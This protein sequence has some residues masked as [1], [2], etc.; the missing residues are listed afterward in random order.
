[1]SYNRI[2][3]SHRGS[4]KKIVSDYFNTLSS[5]GYRPWMD[6]SDLTT[7]TALVKSLQEGM[8][9]SCAAV[10][11]V[12][13]AFKDEGYLR[14]EI[15]Y[16]LNQNE[17]W[18]N[19][20]TIITLIFDKNVKIPDPLKAY[21]YKYPTTHLEGLRIIINAIPKLKRI[22][23]YLPLPDLVPL[24]ANEVA[25]VGQNLAGRLGLG[26]EQ[27][28]LKFKEELESLLTRDSL[29]SLVL[30]MMTPKVL[31]SIHQEAAKDMKNSTLRGLE[32]LKSDLSDKRISVIFHPASTLSVLAVD[33][34]NIN[35][36][37]AIITPK[38]QRTHDIY[39]RISIL[40][41]ERYFDSAPL[42]RM[43]RDGRDK[44][45]GVFMADLTNAPDL[46]KSLLN[47][48]GI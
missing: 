24:Q 9:S 35:K 18:G 8:A 36:A 43:I 11:F 20:F 28:Y 3:L 6:V 37:F 26:E 31:Y 12:T 29:K 2:F 44:E 34:S 39:G 27:N 23:G 4:D 30:V 10:F 5:F 19:G 41:D 14:A 47:D 7:G 33:W 38:F 40:M 22:H 1:M 13:Q 45:D 46:L 17:I 15:N 48:A 32:W 21:L 16:A 42:T 25:V